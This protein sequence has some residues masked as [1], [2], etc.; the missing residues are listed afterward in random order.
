MKKNSFLILAA[1]ILTAALLLLSY[2]EGYNKGLSKGYKRVTDTVTKIK[3]EVKFVDV[4]VPSLPKIVSRAD[5]VIV[6]DTI[7]IPTKPF[8]ATKDTSYF[9]YQD[10]NRVCYDSIG[11]EFK[12]PG[13]T[14]TLKPRFGAIPIRETT[15]E[16]TIEIPIYPTTWDKVGYYGKGGLVGFL[17]GAAVG[18]YI[19]NNK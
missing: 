1:A 11:V 2:C 5:T 3:T 9:R 14:F 15:I 18:I 19:G 12:Y 10:S 17:I 13:Y 8:V 16:K 4:K 7:L 6:T